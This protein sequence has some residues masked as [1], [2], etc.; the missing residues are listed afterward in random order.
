[1]LHDLKIADWKWISSSH[2]GMMFKDD[3]TGEWLVG[4]SKDVIVGKSY[5]VEISGG[6]NK[7]DYR[8]INKFIGEIAGK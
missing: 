8:L 2:T 4:P 5:L 7:D 1:M 6:L 3:A